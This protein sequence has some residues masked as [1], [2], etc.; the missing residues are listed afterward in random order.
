MAHLAVL[1]AH[2]GGLW[3]SSGMRVYITALV[4]F[5]LFMLVPVIR[6]KMR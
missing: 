6:A 3:Q 2:I 5:A 4:V 1:L